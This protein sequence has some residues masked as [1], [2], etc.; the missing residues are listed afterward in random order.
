MHE[1]W[2]LADSTYLYNVGLDIRI[3]LQIRPMVYCFSSQR[4]M[5][6]FRLSRSSALGTRLGIPR[7]CGDGKETHVLLAL[8]PPAKKLFYHERKI[9]KF[10]HS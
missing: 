1:I 5:A 9:P 6:M 3:I 2:L 10:R 4:L 7:F 8:K